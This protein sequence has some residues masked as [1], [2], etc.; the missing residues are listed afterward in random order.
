MLST[1]IGDHSSVIYEKFYNGAMNKMLYGYLNEVVL[2]FL[3]HPQNYIFI[4]NLRD[5]LTSEKQCYYFVTTEYQKWSW[6]SKGDHWKEARV[7][8]AVFKGEMENVLWYLHWCCGK[9]Q[10]EEPRGLGLPPCHLPCYLE[11]VA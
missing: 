9:D 4:F 6:P 5:L 10:C 7:I 3:L 1:G 8:K 11:Q 2:E